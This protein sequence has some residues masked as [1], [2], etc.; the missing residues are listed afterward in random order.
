MTIAISGKSGCGNS[1]VSRIVA[2]RLGY[3]L[4]NYTFKN[5]AAERGMT[6][7]EVCERAEVDPSFDRELDKKQVAMAREGDTVLGSRLA[8]WMLDDAD[9]KVYLDAPVAVRASRIRQRMLNSGDDAADFHTVLHET[10]ERDQRDHDRYKRLYDIDND[11]FEFVD[12]LIRA[13]QMSPQEIADVIVHNV[14][15]RE[16]KSGR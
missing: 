2:E 16:K 3:R 6:F 15:E 8:I 9:L 5:V 11:Q 4:V 12:L 10:I 14:R 7:E 13:S 1:T